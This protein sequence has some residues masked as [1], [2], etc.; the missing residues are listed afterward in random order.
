MV[1]VEYI[2][3][4]NDGKKDPFFLKKGTKR[5]YLTFSKKYNR[6]TSPDT[7]MINIYE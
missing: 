7:Y 2:S 3:L 6:L 5:E 1:T 4:F